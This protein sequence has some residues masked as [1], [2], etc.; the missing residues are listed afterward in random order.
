MSKKGTTQQLRSEHIPASNRVKSTAIILAL[1]CSEDRN[2][3][4][5]NFSKIWESIQAAYS[6]ASYIK[7]PNMDNTS[8]GDVQSA[9]VIFTA[10]SVLS[11]VANCTQLTTEFASL[12]S[13][14]LP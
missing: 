4:G 8:Y 1:L 3:S 5:S 11:L 9:S 2:T 14:H 6:T 7:A 13:V 12:L 10:T